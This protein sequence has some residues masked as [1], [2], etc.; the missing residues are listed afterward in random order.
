MGW[1][2]TH[3]MPEESVKDFFKRQFDF[4]NSNR[5]GE[6][7]ECKVVKLRTAYIAFKVINRE[8]NTKKIRAIVCLLD[9]RSNEYQNI[10]YK[11]MD[12]SMLPNAQECPQSI[13]KLLTDT[14]NENAIEWRQACRDTIKERKTNNN[15]Y[16]RLKKILQKGDIITLKSGHQ[17]EFSFVAGRSI[18]GYSVVRR[19]H[20]RL[21]A[22][23]I[24]FE[25]TRN[26][27]LTTV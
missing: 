9:Y 3:K 8:T 5:K 18:V 26:C 10:G 4:D 13:L 27:V 21:P 23:M 17:Y 7:L 25:T 22:R 15:Q 11:D 6:V 16:T 19:Q 12:E 14:D 1:L 20:Y 2:Y 24:D